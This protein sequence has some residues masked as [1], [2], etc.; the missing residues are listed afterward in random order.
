MLESM[1]HMLKSGYKASAPMPVSNIR[2]GSVSALGR[3]YNW[4]IKGATITVAGGR[5]YIRT[6]RGPWVRKEHYDAVRSP[7]NASVNLGCNTWIRED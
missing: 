7:K 5:Q 3:F 1:L 4:A 2:K 6:N